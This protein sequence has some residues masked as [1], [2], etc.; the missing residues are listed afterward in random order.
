MQALVSFLLVHGKVD[1]LTIKIAELTPVLLLAPQI[2]QMKY[3]RQEGIVVG[4]LYG[5]II[6]TLQQPIIK[7]ILHVNLCCIRRRR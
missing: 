3:S 2:M 7:V 1:C 6:Q 4:T 5:N